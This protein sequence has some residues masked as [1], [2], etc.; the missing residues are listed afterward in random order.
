MI[1][2]TDQKIIFLGTPQFAVPFLQALAASEFRPA[3]VIT[4][5]DQKAGRQQTEQAPAVKI[6]QAE[7]PDVCIL[8]A[9]GALIPA[10]I[11][12]IPRFGFINAHPSLLPQYRGPAPVQNVI[13]NGD[14]FT[15]ITLI[16]LDEKMDHGP[17]MAQEKLPILPTDNNATLH[18]RLAILGADL[19]VKILPDYLAGKIKPQPQDD[20]QVSLTKIIKRENGQLDWSKS[21]VVL[22][23]QFRAFFPWPGIFTYWG[24]KRLKIANLS[25]WEAN[26]DQNLAPGTVFWQ[27]NSLGVKCGQGAIKPERLQLE[28]KKEMAAMD[29][30]RGY[31]EIVGSRLR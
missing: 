19:L 16:K 2:P 10:E 22:E 5:P 4:Q 18:D 27:Q 25:L 29:F 7:K 21:A 8:V 6:L 17:I 15:G 13:L 28:G 20:S 23:R 11:L 3:L 26:F 12:T 1:K 14:E 31:K 30:I 9:Y 24:K